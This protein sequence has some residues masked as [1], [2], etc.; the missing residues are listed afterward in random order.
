V[1]EEVKKLLHFNDFS[2][3]RPVVPVYKI[4]RLMKMEW[5]LKNILLPSEY[6]DQIR[7]LDV[8]D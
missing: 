2:L 8:K 4:T 7:A 3:L 5:L 1:P 6:K